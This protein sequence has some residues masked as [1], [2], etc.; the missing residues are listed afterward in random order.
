MEHKQLKFAVVGGDSRQVRLCKLLEQDG[1]FVRTFGLEHYRFETGILPCESMEQ[2]A[3]GANCVIF[4]M[5]MTQEGRLNGPLAA[6]PLKPERLLE[7]LPQDC[8]VMGGMVPDG[9]HQAAAKRGITLHDYLL[10]EELAL[11]NA[12]ITAEGALQIAMEN[13]DHTLW[14]S[15]CLV[16]GYGRIGKILCQRLRG[17]GARV[18]AAARKCAD[19]A[20][21]RCDCLETVETQYLELVLPQQEIIF[22]TAP[23]LVLPAHRLE[24]VDPQAVIIDL[25]SKPGGAGFRAH[26][27][28]LLFWAPPITIEG[29]N[30]ASRGVVAR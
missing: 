26:R 21:A 28:G 18:T 23:G 22:N 10:R 11:L 12:A 4:P 15:D 5:P 25:A 9:V 20:Q 17:L 24:L 27:P 2:A 14:G 3:L 7:A 29:K 16:I 30:P 19:L 8:L 1:H 13:T 6:Q